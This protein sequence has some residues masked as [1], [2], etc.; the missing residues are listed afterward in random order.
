MRYVLYSE[1]TSLTYLVGHAMS[2]HFLTTSL[3]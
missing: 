1:S 3:I 2:N